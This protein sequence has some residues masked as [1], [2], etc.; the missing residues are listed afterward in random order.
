MAVALV[1]TAL[2]QFLKSLFACPDLY[3][4]SET[5]FLSLKGEFIMSGNAFIE[6]RQHVWIKKEY[7]TKP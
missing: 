7:K 1:L 5:Y 4:A 2:S 3:F 6:Q